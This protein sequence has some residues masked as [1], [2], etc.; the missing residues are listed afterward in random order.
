MNLTDAEIADRLD[1]MRCNQSELRKSG[2]SNSNWLT[3]TQF[4]PY[5]SDDVISFNCRDFLAFCCDVVAKVDGKCRW[6]E[7]WEGNWCTECG[8]GFTLT[9]G[10]PTD[11]RMK[12]C[13]Y[14]GKPLEQVE[15]KEAV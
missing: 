3:L 12:F 7:D 1:G 4:S 15:Y 14:C 11:N 5:E 8:E 13:T 2:G 6:V 10:K 9:S